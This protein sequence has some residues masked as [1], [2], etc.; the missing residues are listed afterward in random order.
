MKN[1]GQKSLLEHI[2]AAS[3]KPHYESTMWGVQ[4]SLFALFFFYL[5]YFLR[6]LS[7]LQYY[8]QFHRYK[9]NS[10]TEQ[11]ERADFHAFNT[12]LYLLIVFVFFLG[13]SFWSFLNI[14]T[15]YGQVILWLFLVESIFWVLY[16]MLF[17]ILMER[18][19]SIFHEAEYFLCLPIVIATQTLIIAALIHSPEFDSISMLSAIFDLGNLDPALPFKYAVLLKFLGF[20]YTTVII[21]NLINLLPSIPVVR[22]QNVTIIG[23]G[24]VVENRMLGALLEIYRPSQIS[25]VSQDISDNFKAILEQ[26]K[27]DHHCFNNINQIIDYIKSR[28]SFAIIATPTQYHYEYI[29]RLNKEGIPFAVEKPLTHIRA[30]L[31]ELKTNSN[32]MKNGFL[33]SYYWLEK[34]LPLNF[35]LTLNPEYAKYIQMIEGENN[36][37]N[38]V[39]NISRLQYYKLK[40]GDIK[41]I[42]LKLIESDEKDERLWSLEDENG[43]MVFETLI[44]P[45]TLL[46]NLCPSYENM[47]VN[48]IDFFSSDSSTNSN[49]TGM[50]VA[51]NINKTKFLIEID[52]NIKKKFERNL[53]IAYEFGEIVVDFDQK[54]CLIMLY[55][56]EKIEL[57]IQKK[58]TTKYEVQMMLMDSF[59]QNNCKWEWLRYDDYPN[60]ID[61]LLFLFD[62]IYKKY[63]IK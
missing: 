36:T 40:L 19:L 30:Y 3:K 26:K 6:F 63:I 39:P 7:P 15:W 9:N 50:Q 12:E 11:K 49:Y 44:H 31:E 24:D 53:K 13:N 20:I 2:K 4:R 46:C 8:K 51:G 37:I 43:G 16:Y 41:S 29:I 10:K 35:F 56:G 60:Q 58:F 62:K 61:V 55:T 34:A 5:V 42:T 17:R 33:L 32:I 47:H 59:I 48:E 1:K 54:N 38:E 22:R 27:I 18:H 21:A 14:D 52:K 23:A 28:S 57:K 25:I 45:M